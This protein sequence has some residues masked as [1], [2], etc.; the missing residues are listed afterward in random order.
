MQL[1]I[2]ANILGGELLR[3]RGRK[4]IQHPEL[5]LYVTSQVLNETNYEIK[6]RLSAR[7]HGGKI[8]ES[9]GLLLLNLAMVLINT[10][11]NLV[12]LSNYLHLESVAKNRITSD[13]DDWQTVA[14]ALY[15]NADIWTE[16]YDFLGCVC[17]TWTTETLL[18]HLK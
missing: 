1:I 13:P 12:D 8:T 17:A 10:K 7:V 9:D 6:R 4:L 2:D 11:I 18:L 15:L 16:D 3:E 14:L 5:E